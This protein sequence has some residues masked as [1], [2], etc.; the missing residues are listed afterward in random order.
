MKNNRQ[1]AIKDIITHKQICNQDELR[2]ELKKRGI[3]VTQTTLSRDLK[4]LGV[5]R[6]S[7]GNEFHYILQPGSTEVDMLRPMITRQVISIE[8]NESIIVVKTLPGCANVVGEYLDAQNNS[9]IIGTLAGDN[10]LLIIPSSAKKTNNVVEF[11]KKKLIER[12]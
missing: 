8:A 4:E 12:I 6:I 1:F 9:A 3:D 2:L 10:T 7:A 5:G 11:L